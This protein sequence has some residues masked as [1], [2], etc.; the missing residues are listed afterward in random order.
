[1][2]L[3]TQVSLTGR[4]HHV[5]SVGKVWNTVTWGRTDSAIRKSIGLRNKGT[6]SIIFYYRRFV[7][8]TSGVSIQRATC[9]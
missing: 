7:G 1:M 4:T 8:R 9:S 5:T 2:V 3:G 6:Q